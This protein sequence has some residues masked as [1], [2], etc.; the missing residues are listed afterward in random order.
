MQIIPREMDAPNKFE[1]DCWTIRTTKAVNERI[2]PIKLMVLLDFMASD[3]R[4]LT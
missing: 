2:A 1:E 4:K 3:L